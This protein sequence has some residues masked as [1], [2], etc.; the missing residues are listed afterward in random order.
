M[1]IETSVKKWYGKKTFIN[2]QVKIGIVRKTFTGIQFLPI[3]LICLK[4]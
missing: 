1:S 4:T 3:P 2:L